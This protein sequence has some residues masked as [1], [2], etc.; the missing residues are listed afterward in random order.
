MDF[1][2]VPG[3]KPCPD[4]ATVQAALGLRVDWVSGCLFKWNSDGRSHPN[5][6]CPKGWDCTLDIGPRNIAVLGDGS[7]FDIDSGSFFPVPDRTFA[8]LCGPRG[9]F[10]HENIYAYFAQDPP[11]EAGN[12]KCDAGAQTAGVPNTT[13]V[14]NPSPTPAPAPAAAAPAPAFDP[15][16]LVIA[17]D[18]S[19][20]T[21][22][23]GDPG[24]YVCDANKTNVTF[25]HPGGESVIDI[26]AGFK[27]PAACTSTVSDQTRT[28]KCP[29]GTSIVADRWTVKIK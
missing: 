17:S 6:P 7:T 4:V 13:T 26:W 23:A 14:P 2:L 28:L 15:L 12:F 29:A 22:T 3:V 9:Y 19:K 24:V 1:S 21:C 27:F 25:T 16:T 20:V 18:Q 5:T 11:T 8:D 10:T